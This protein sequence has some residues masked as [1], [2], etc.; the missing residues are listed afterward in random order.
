M[1]GEMKMKKKECWL[2]I[3]QQ[4]PICMSMNGKNCLKN[5]IITKTTIGLYLD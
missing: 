3:K 2:G 1:L 4:K 5:V